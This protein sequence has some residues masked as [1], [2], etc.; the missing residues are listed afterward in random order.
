[1]H[2]RRQ[3][4]RQADRQLSAKRPLAALSHDPHLPHR[5][6]ARTWCLIEASKALAILSTRCHDVAG[7]WDG[8]GVGETSVADLIGI[9]STKVDLRELRILNALAV[10]P[11]N[12]PVKAFWQCSSDDDG[13]SAALRL[14][15]IR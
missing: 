1:M 5:R 3:T 14:R 10:I 7:A 9:W 12:M 8:S 4:G 2:A 6:N 13:G 15:G 11:P